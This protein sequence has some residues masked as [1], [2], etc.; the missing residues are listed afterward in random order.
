M[1]YPSP[2]ERCSVCSCTNGCVEWRIRYLYRQ[3]QINA[4]ARQ[5]CQPRP[6]EIKAFQYAHPDEYLNYLRHSPCE[7]CN[8]NNICDTPCAAYLQWW[9]ARMGHFGRNYV[10]T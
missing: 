2:C 4:Y 8:V 3:K 5:I 9:D 7:G 10:K 6:V 1:S